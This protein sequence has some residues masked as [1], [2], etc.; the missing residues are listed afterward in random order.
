MRP[1]SR[2]NELSTYQ[3][4]H[5]IFVFS[6]RQRCIGGASEHL[7]LLTVIDLQR[8]Q[9]A[10]SPERFADNPAINTTGALCES[11]VGQ[12]EP[13]VNREVYARF[14][15]RLRVRLPGPTRH[16]QFKRTTARSM[17]AEER[18][19]FKDINAPPNDPLSRRHKRFSSI[20]S[21]RPTAPNCAY[22]A[23]ASDTVCFCKGGTSTLRP[24]SSVINW[25][26]LM[27]SLSFR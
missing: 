7:L 6:W 11:K 15:E 17:D 19:R 21:A 18:Y 10:N 9:F 12:Q 13:C 8:M 26:P 16:W 3:H 25:I 2:S 5:S 24:F 22:E 1:P 27:V 23:H 14:R 20:L 4:R